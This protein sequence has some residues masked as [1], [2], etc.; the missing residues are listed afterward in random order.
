[1]P[2]GLMLI[3]TKLCDDLDYRA[4]NKKIL[5]VIEHATSETHKVHVAMGH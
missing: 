3:V 5:V 2:D 1:M 4:T